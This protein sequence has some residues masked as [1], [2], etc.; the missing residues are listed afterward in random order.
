MATNELNNNQENQT[1]EKTFTQ[2]ELNAIVQDRIARE[3]AK[4]ENFEELKEKAQK[5]DQIEEES[6]SELQKATEKANALQNELD[7]M[8]KA[9]EIRSIRDKVAKEKGVPAEL[10]NFDTEEACAEQADKI[11]S[12]AHPDNYPSVQDGGEPA[13]TIDGKG[14]GTAEQFAEWFEENM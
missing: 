7:A 14:K 13:N 5:F 9:D 11:L 1:E 6:K 10:L 12:F 2:A 4:Y 3:R 8:K